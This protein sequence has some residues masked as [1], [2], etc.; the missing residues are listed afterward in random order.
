MRLTPEELQE[1]RGWIADC[2]WADLDPEDIDDL[3]DEQVLRGIARNYDGGI[4]GFKA[5]VR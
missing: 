2:A 3:T 1:A 4:A 5:D